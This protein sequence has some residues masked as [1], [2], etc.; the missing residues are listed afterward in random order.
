MAYARVDLNW[1][2]TLGVRIGWQWT[3]IPWR[4][5]ICIWKHPA[6]VRIIVLIV[7]PQPTIKCGCFPKITYCGSWR[8]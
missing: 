1:L 8:R 5:A 3:P 2:E 7:C 4:I 6:A